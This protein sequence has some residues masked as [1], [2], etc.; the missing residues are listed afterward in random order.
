M[1]TVNRSRLPVIVRRRAR[2]VWTHEA[3]DATDTD[4][5]SF[6]SASLGLPA[7]NR[8]I[9]LCLA[10]RDFGGS[11][12][13]LSSVTLDGVSMSAIIPLTVDQADNRLAVY[14]L[15]LPSAATTGTFAVTLSGATARFGIQVAAMYGGQIT[16][17]DTGEINFT[18]PT[19]TGSDTLAVVPGGAIIGYNL[20][21]GVASPP[22][23]TYT[24]LNKAAASQG[25]LEGNTTHGFACHDSGGGGMVT[26]NVATD[27][28]VNTN[29]KTLLAS[30]PPQRAP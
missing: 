8:I 15:A 10:S 22:V 24:R 13:T 7:A 30:F 12:R 29:N 25:T 6:A 2:I 1:F 16:P 18:T 11:S 21:I 14:G 23:S 27:V 4:S 19:T 9:L 17:T 5:Y 26:I 3:H 20:F 28:E